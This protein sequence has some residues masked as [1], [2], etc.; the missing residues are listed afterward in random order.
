MDLMDSALHRLQIMDNVMLC[1]TLPTTFDSAL[2]ATGL[3]AR[4]WI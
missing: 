4:P 2:K 3:V 1:S